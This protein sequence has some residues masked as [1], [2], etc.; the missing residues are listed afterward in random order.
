MAM[1]HMEKSYPPHFAVYHNVSPLPCFL[2][3]TR[4]LNRGFESPTTAFDPKRPVASV[5]NR[6]ANN[7]IETNLVGC[8]R[9]L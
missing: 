8:G 3:I 1:T 4:L 5:R 2:Q 9:L 7:M 6:E